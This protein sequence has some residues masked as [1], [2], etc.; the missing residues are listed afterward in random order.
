M[1]ALIPK[2]RQGNRGK[3]DC[4]ICAAFVLLHSSI[5]GRRTSCTF[6]SAKRNVLV[7]DDRNSACLERERSFGLLKTNHVPLLDE[8]AR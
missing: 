5:R 1:H 7:L 3:R 4:S 2:Q 8:K 6:Q